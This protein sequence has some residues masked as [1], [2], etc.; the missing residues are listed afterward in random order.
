MSNK[1]YEQNGNDA[2]PGKVM[3]ITSTEWENPK[4][5]TLQWQLKYT[6]RLW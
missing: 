6:Q 2:I 1:Q 3:N 5:Q 4:H